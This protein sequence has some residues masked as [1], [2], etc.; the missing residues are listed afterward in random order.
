MKAA[1]VYDHFPHYREAILRELVTCSVHEFVLASDR[2]SLDPSIKTAH[3]PEEMEWVVCPCAALP[4]GGIYQKG[5][6]HLA[7]RRDLD[8]IIYLGCPALISIWP[9]A[10]VARITGKRV[11][12]WTHGWTRPDTWLRGMAKR[13]FYSLADT[14]LLYGNI[15]RKLGIESGFPA[16][17]MDVIYNS[18]DYDAHALIRN[19]A[20]LEE[21]AA[22]YRSLLP[23]P[24]LPSVICTARLTESCRFDLLF[25]A[26]RSL[27]STGNQ[28]NVLL[29][30]DGPMR[31][32]LE[33]QCAG[34]MSEYVCFYGACY[35]EEILGKLLMGAR[36]TVSPGKVGLTAVH[37]MAF[38]T[39]V[40]THDN[41]DHQGPEVEAVIPGF[42]GELFREG[43]A[44]SLARVIEKFLNDSAS[45]ASRDACIEVVSRF[46]NPAYQRETID[47]VLSAPLGLH[48]VADRRSVPESTPADLFFAPFEGNR[49]KQWAD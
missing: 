43:D 10:L 16:E 35:D 4:A 17:R 45:T 33:A 46:F 2:C 27:A 14:L 7:L 8:A 37:S 36:V 22:L 15:A 34:T 21:I 29:V 40:I 30:G 20:T 24:E 1:I 18:L 28:F 44:Q 13:L 38:G 32:A 39:P 25:E 19:Q 49:G 11:F 26:Q 12:Y 6:V 41:A 48:K 47:R 3:L 5:L 9:S 23:H 31:S 42:T